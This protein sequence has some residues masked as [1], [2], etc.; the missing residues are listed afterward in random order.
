MAFHLIQFTVYGVYFFENIS[1]RI[2]TNFVKAFSLGIS[3]PILN[4]NVDTTSG[5][6]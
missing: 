1:S 5:G 3:A 4:E 2:S 6:V